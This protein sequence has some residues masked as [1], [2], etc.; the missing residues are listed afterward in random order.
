MLANNKLRHHKN[1]VRKPVT[2]DKNLGVLKTAVLYGSNAAGK[3]NI[4][5]AVEHALSIICGQYS[6]NK[7]LTQEHFKL[8]KQSSNK[9]TEFYFEFCQIGYRGSYKFSFLKNKIIEEELHLYDKKNS[10]TRIFS[11]HDENEKMV[12][13]SELLMPMDRKQAVEKIIKE[14]KSADWTGILKDFEVHSAMHRTPKD[15]LILS[16]IATRDFSDLENTVVDIIC[17]VYKFFKT[18]I[19]VVY[20]ESRYMG[21]SNHLKDNNDSS[22]FIKN[23]LEF[24]TGISDLKSNSYD[25]SSL[26]DSFLSK[27]KSNLKKSSIDYDVVEIQGKYISFYIDNDSGDLKA[28][29][30]KAVH[31]GIDGDDVTFEI[32]EESD[33][34]IRL[35]DL[36]PAVCY[37]FKLDATEH[38]GVTYFIDEFNRSLHPAVARKFIQQFLTKTADNNCQLIVSTHESELLDFK[39]LRRDEIYFVQKEKNNATELY[40]LDEYSTRFDKDIRRAY[41]SG[42]F[43]AIPFEQV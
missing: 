6:P 4:F 12:I 17:D 38:T 34:T 14:G 5:K 13:E 16:E 24:N 3:S 8:D 35:I 32:S 18:R 42:K 7:N 28:D 9:K 19:T 26:D 29:I 33:G 23:F 22:P 36:L 2:K 39:I 20:P 27:I 15:K 1:H 30:L 40:S 43:G 10:T 11:R 25:I 37:D 21:V 41:L 31:K